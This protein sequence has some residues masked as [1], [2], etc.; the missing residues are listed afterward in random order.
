MSPLRRRLCN[1]ADENANNR[2]SRQTIIWLACGVA[3]V[4]AVVILFAYACTTGQLSGMLYRY[5]HGGKWLYSALYHGLRNGDTREQVEDLLGPG[6]KT[7]SAK[8][9]E[10]TKKIAGSNPAGY[11]HGVEDT[12]TFLGFLLPGGELFLQFRDGVLINFDPDDFAKYES[13]RTIG[14]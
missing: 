2:K 5:T 13:V 1:M 10:V 3:L 8:I 7:D 6:R 12:D 4:L 9:V 14:Q 11:P